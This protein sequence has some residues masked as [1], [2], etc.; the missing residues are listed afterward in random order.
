[1]FWKKN[2]YSSNKDEIY[3]KSVSRV[4][5][6]IYSAFAFSA[7]PVITFCP[8]FYLSSALMMK[9]G[10]LE[11]MMYQWDELKCTYIHLPQSI[12]AVLVTLIY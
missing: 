8:S 4:T 6:P 7:S 3:S 2:A 9:E 5:V 12:S 1:M 10:A 11:F